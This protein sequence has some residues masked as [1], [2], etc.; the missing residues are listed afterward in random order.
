MKHLVMKDIRLIGIMNLVV[1]GTGIL[2][3]SVAMLG[4]EVF[5]SNILYLT[6]VIGA[7]FLINNLIYSKELK[8]KSDA[9]IISLPVN[10][11]DIVK[12]R[13]LTMM[14]YIFGILSI[15]YL[16]SNIGNILFNN[17]LKNSLSLLGMLIIGSIMIILTA[18]YIPFQYY[19]QKS[20]QFFPMVI[21]MLA[22]GGPSMLE[23]LDIDL[24]NLTFI[25]KIFT[26]NFNMLASIFL[27]VALILYMISLFISKEIY[28][29]KEF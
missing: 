19:D 20:A 1:L 12:S 4:Y 16:T 29:A 18:I 17:M 24:Q 14:I 10:K 23:R 13:Y 28:E 26:M 8:S 9:L 15:I 7:W 11:A 25:Q 2:G 27:G 3:G 22:S 6:A 5:V 21:L